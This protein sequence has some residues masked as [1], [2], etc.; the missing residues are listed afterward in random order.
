MYN[1]TKLPSETL[2]A[3]LPVWNDLI[4]I[5]S[6]LDFLTQAEFF[7][8]LKARHPVVPV[9]FTPTYSNDAFQLMGYAVE[10]LTGRKTEELINEHLI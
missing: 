6:S 2:R 8:G 10:R 9:S 7:S 5:L 4:G 3:I 1:G